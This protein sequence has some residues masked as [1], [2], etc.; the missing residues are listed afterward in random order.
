MFFLASSLSGTH[1]M[2]VDLL[3]GVTDQLTGVLLFYLGGNH[4]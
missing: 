4:K 2:C 3:D 1:N